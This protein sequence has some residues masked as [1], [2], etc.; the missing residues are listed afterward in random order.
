MAENWCSGVNIKVLRNSDWQEPVKIIEDKTRSGKQK[1]RYYASNSKR[2]FN[3]T[4]RF[5]LSEYELFRTWYEEDIKCGMY[6][7][8]FPKIDSSTK[9]LTEYRISQSG[10]PKYQNISG[11]IIECGMVWEEV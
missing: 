1:R 9:P 4:M 7:F 6:S 10:T 2:L 5:T 8:L 3:V 11:D